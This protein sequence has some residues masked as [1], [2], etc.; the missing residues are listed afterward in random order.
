ML[1]YCESLQL[2]QWATGWDSAPSANDDN[3]NW[4]T[5]D[6]YTIKHYIWNEGS[7]DYWKYK[8]EKP[9]GAYGSF[10]CAKDLPEE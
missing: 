8:V 3:A 4:Q 1:S 6:S 10:E 2:Y 9:G 7:P 5:L